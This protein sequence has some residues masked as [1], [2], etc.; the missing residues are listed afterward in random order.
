MIKVKRHPQNPILSPN[1]EQN[2]EAVAVFNG[3]IIKDKDKFHLVYRAISSPQRYFGHDI[4]LSSIGKAESNDGINFK[5]RQLLITPEYKW[6]EF[7]CEDPRIT[8]FDDKYF[9]FY[10]ALGDYPHS[11]GGIKIGLATTS[12]FKK[13]SEKH[14]VT[15]FNSKGMALFPEKIEGKMVAVLTVNTD[16]PPAKIAL[17][18]FDRENQIWSKEYWDNWLPS[19]EK[20][21]LPLQREPKDHIE[22]GAPPVKTKYGWL[23]IY[24]YIKNYFSPPPIFGIEAALLDLKEPLRIIGRT[25]EPLIVPKEEYEKYG[26]VPNVIF[27]SGALIQG[28][29]LNIFYGAADT[30]CCLAKVKVE[31]LINAMAFKKPS[32]AKDKKQEQFRLEKHKGNPIIEPISEHEWESKYTLNPGAIYEEGKVHIIYRA[33]GGDETSVLGYASS[34][35]GFKIDERLAEPIYVPREDFE[36]KARPGFSGC[37]DPRI[38]KLGNKFYMCYT[39]FDG[40]NPT[41]IVLTSIKVDDFLNKK[42]NWSR[43]KSISYPDRSDKNACVFPEKIQG[44]YALFHRIGGCI[45]VDTVDDLIFP[46]EQYLGGRMI[47]C[48]TPGRWDS[49]KVGIAGPPFKTKIGWLLIYHGL[50]AEDDEYRLGAMLLDLK[51]PGKILNMLEE[52][53]LEPEEDYELGGFRPG[54]VFSC[55]AVVLKGKLLVYYGAGDHVIGVASC[56]FERLVEELKG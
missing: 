2:W 34:K 54:T 46:G 19:L 21:A 41:R 38:T 14:Q 49:R 50:S 52:P 7:G 18:F 25:H 13:I 12:D 40:Q 35:D 30:T 8:K 29:K 9:I 22:V 11:P 4:E 31:D 36:K 3:S 16:R 15:H 6:E 10:T 44:Q 45:W 1:E 42:W 20:F 37:E 33:M 17:A 26:K 51:E 55:G 39:A 5:N 28:E 48:P 43:P 56:D 32:P 53:I 27:P 23:L 24:S 47:L